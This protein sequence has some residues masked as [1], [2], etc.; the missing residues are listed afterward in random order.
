MKMFQTTVV[1]AL[2]AIAGL[3]YLIWDQGRPPPEDP[4]AGL[5]AAID[6]ARLILDE[7]ARQGALIRQREILDQFQ[8]ND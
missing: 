5:N 3:L 8:S 6:N 4:Y 2:I 1:V 7:H